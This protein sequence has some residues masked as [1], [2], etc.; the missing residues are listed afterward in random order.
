MEARRPD[1]L[2]W[3]ESV[4]GREWS[5]VF[6]P[7][8]LQ[9][10]PLLVGAGLWD[11]F[12]VMLWMGLSRAH[13]PARAFLFPV[14]HAIVG[15]VVTWMALA[16]TLNVLRITVNPTELVIRQS[17]IPRAGTRIRTETVD[18]FEV[19]DSKGTWRELRSVRAVMRDGQAVKLDLALDG[20]AEV[21]YVAGR[22]NAALAAVRP[23]PRE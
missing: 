22:L 1:G 23:S 18:H 10:V 19:H 11:S 14:A 4:A 17:P 3:S 13:A 20:L 7:S 8:R 9:S 5:I 21:A 16:R 12:F 2:E 15:L 6:S